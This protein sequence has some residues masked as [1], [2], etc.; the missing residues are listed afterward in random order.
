[1]GRP[2]SARCL[3]VGFWV[4]AASNWSLI[5]GIAQSK[6]RQ[7]TVRR[8]V[9]HG[10]REHCNWSIG[11]SHPWLP[12]AS[13]ISTVDITT[14]TTLPPRVTFLLSLTLIRL[15][16]RSFVRSFVSPAA[17]THT[18]LLFPPP[19]TSP[20]YP[21]H[22]PAAISAYNLDGL[23]SSGATASSF[24]AVTANERETTST[25]L[26]GVATFVTRRG[27]GGRGRGRGL[28]NISIEYYLGFDS[29]V[30]GKFEKELLL[31]IIF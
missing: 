12:F 3:D 29:L 15:R 22:A 5:P 31:G 21:F 26:S 2:L 19:S 17:H 30:V 4:R 14:L 18:P 25:T 27:G 13:T 23:E 20:L 8:L 16:L 28:E 7:H 24:S 11:P 6:N 1:M 9:D 10:H